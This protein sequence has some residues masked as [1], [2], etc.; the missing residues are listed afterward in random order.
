MDQ[1]T[2]KRLEIIP[3]IDLRIDAFPLLVILPVVSV[4][5]RMAVAMG[6]M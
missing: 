6:I 1:I 3:L 5:G 4:R 2:N